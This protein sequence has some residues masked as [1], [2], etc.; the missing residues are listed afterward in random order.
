[1]LSSSLK[2]LCYFV[3]FQIHWCCTIA[4]SSIYSATTR[5]VSPTNSTSST[6]RLPSG[7]LHPSFNIFDTETLM[8]VSSTNAHGL[9]D[10]IAKGF[11]MTATSESTF[12]G[13]PNA[14]TSV[15]SSHPSSA[16][17]LHKQ[18]RASDRSTASAPQQNA[19]N[20]T[21]LPVS[22]TSNLTTL[23]TS[24]SNSSL[25]RSG[26]YP[27]EEPTTRPVW[28]NRS[29]TLSGDC[30]NQ[31]SQFWSAEDWPEQVWT[32][33]SE[34]IWTF[35]TTED[36]GG[37][38]TSTFLSYYTTTVFNGRFP[39]TTYSTLAPVTEIAWV[40]GTPTET[41]T[42]TR[43]VDPGYSVITGPPVLLQSPLCVLPSIVP[44]CQESWDSWVEWETRGEN[45]ASWAPVD[46][47]PGCNPYATTMIPLSCQAPLSKWDS[48]RASYYA[49]AETPRCS[50]AKLADDYCSF[51]RSQFLWRGEMK[52]YYFSDAQTTATT[53]DGITTHVEV[54]PSNTTIRG[55]GCTLG[56]GN[57][58]LQGETVELIFWHPA[59]SLTNGTAVNKT[60]EPVTI[61]TL[62]TTFTS[63]T[64][65]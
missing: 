1:M 24:S 5:H 2:T 52:G 20:Q 17:T 7:L 15:S 32:S 4:Y 64:V 23:H 35:T 40:S 56:C 12:T 29:L 54:W 38:S 65:C 55:P 31:W 27:M 46:G 62:G 51:T 43:T 45:L 9:G 53:I 37:V 26:Y 44:Q 13:P 49:R 48:A 21:S 42:G 60:L 18:N 25:R 33:H 41:W 61:E 3:T 6:S 47:P 19:R 63:P 57:C 39:V 28:L 30:W 14:T 11:G 59:T 8:S 34:S 10:F 50:Q 16:P 22:S 58:A 36:D